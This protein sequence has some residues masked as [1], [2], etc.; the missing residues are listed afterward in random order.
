[1]HDLEDRV[2]RLEAGRN[3]VGLRSLRTEAFA[4]RRGGVTYVRSQ[5]VRKKCKPSRT[6]SRATNLRSLS[7][8]QDLRSQLEEM[9]RVRNEL[10]ARKKALQ[11]EVKR[12]EKRLKSE[13]KKKEKKKK[14]KE[15]GSVSY[16]YSDETANPIA[17][18]EAGVYAGVPVAYTGMVTRTGFVPPLLSQEGGVLVT[19]ATDYTVLMPSGTVGPLVSGTVGPLFAVSPGLV[20][21]ELVGP[22]PDA[23]PA[24][25]EAL[26]REILALVNELRKNMSGLREDVQSL[27]H[28]VTGID[29]VR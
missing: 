22:R 26:L 14:T 9:Q 16:L 19:G 21:G 13:Q 5:P 23:S 3:S 25:Q 8:G 10:E 15:K 18:N 11:S 4:P 1:L 17:I 7:E 6:T 29:R 28:E 27:H 24:T 2:G 20:E 12:Q